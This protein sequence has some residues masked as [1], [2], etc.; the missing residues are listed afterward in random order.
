MLLASRVVADG[1]RQ[2]TLSV[3]AIHCGACI[4]AVEDVISD[5]PGIEAARVNL[6]TRRVSVSWR[7]ERPP[8]IIRPLA[9]IGYEAHLQDTGADERDPRLDELLRSLAVAGFAAM[10]VMLLSV[11]VWTG[12]DAATRDLF[13]WISAA[14][15]FPARLFSGR[16]FFRPAWNAVRHGHTNMD[17]P[18]SIGVLL[19]YGLSLYE[20]IH[21]G[22]YAYFDASV[23]LLFVLLIGR[24]LDHLVRERARSAVSGLARLGARGAMVLRPDGSRDYLPTDEIER[25]MR[26]LLAP[27]ERVP[28][29]ARVEDGTSEID[30]SLVTGE[31]DP[32]QV[33][34]G[35]E[36]LSGT[37]NLT[38][39]L[40][41]IATGTARDSFFCDML[42][43]V[44]A[45]ENA[46]PARV[47][48]VD[49][50]A[51]LYAP[52][53]HAAAALALLGWLIANGDL[54]QAVTVA[55]AVLIITCPCALGLAVPMVQVAAA[56]RLFEAGVMVKDG[57]AVEQVLDV[58]VVVFDKTGTLTE[59]CRL[60]ADKHATDSAHLAL[61]A[62]IAA[63]S[64]HPQSRALAVHKRRDDPPLVFDGVKE[65][66]G[67]GV[68]ATMGGNVYRLGRAEWALQGGPPSRR[69]GTVLSKNGILLQVFR[70]S[71][72]I[73]P[74]AAQTVAELGR[75]RLSV[76]VI[77]GDRQDSVRRTSRAVGIDRFE[78]EAMPARKL[79]RLAELSHSGQKVLMVGDGLNDAPA[80]AAADVSMAPA[81]AADIGRS[82]AGFVFLY[83]SLGAVPHSIAL[84]RRAGL[85]IRQNLAFAVAYNAMAFPFAALG[86][87]TPLIA[88][89]AMS[90]SSLLVVA[91]SLRLDRYR[92]DNDTAEGKRQVL[93]SG[94]T[95]ETM[96]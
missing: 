5:L 52:V 55:V 65:H 53:V 63:Y 22:E 45:A 49:K 73:R 32:R 3:P 67:L 1:V 35:A 78:A 16:V 51:G 15:A 36:L 95:V 70:F 57:A 88:A 76:E 27:G 34:A 79:A 8:S 4:R 9:Q 77:S 74:G 7:G 17:V 58:D 25:G 75:M 81:D 83:R 2:V 85:L 12:A 11:S 66:P 86:Y 47:S 6:S 44:E 10:N 80:L 41:I 26:I 20:T 48:I 93:H 13:H 50:V 42:R 84:S 87:V 82:A 19:A 46:R 59:N 92:F 28:V 31:G 89:L 30:Y 38:A 24:T 96:S 91:N 54:H 72:A 40:T 33:G 61:A 90:G 14:I 69:D 23:T 29:D 62:G 68:E 64:S 60:I 21:R 94:H 39:P 43:L 56:R 37:L 18:I 71:D